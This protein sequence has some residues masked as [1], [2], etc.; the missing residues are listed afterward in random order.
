MPARRRTWARP[1][2]PSS[3]SATTCWQRSQKSLP[4]M[5]NY[6]VHAENGS[7]YNTPPAFAVY[8]LGLVMKWLIGQGGLQA[9]AAV[10][11]RKAA[12]LYAEIDRTGFYRG[13]AHEGLPVADE[14]HVPARRP[15]ISRSAFVKES[16]AAGLDGL[17]G[18]RVGRRHAR[19]D[20]QRV[21]G[22][23]RRRAR[24]VHAG[25]RARRAGSSCDSG[26]SAFSRVRTFRAYRITCYHLAFPPSARRVPRVRSSALFGGVVQCSLHCS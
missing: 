1:A 10:N 21:S 25:V 17:K 18:H 15:K 11:E 26:R 13:T 12:K 14:R 2:S 3:S 8:A 24:R 20:L 16:T 5:L 22:R 7:L 4:T 19:V 9:I 6:A 23:G